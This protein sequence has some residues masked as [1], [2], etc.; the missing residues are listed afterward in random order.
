[1]CIKTKGF[2]SIRINTYAKQGKGGSS[3]LITKRFAF[4]ELAQ[5]ALQ[6]FAQ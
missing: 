1:M 2:I 6:H 4:C 3:L 5:R